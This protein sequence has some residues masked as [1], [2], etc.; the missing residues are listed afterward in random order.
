M[1]WNTSGHVITHKHKELKLNALFHGQ[2][3]QLILEYFKA[4]KQAH[5]NKILQLPYSSS[6]STIQNKYMHNLHIP[7][8]KADILHRLS[9]TTLSDNAQGSSLCSLNTKQSTLHL[10]TMLLDCILQY[11]T[12]LNMN[13]LWQNKM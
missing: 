11:L 12:V 6:D 10:T 7:I 1:G 13:I 4:N 2:P 9:I 8:A 5:Y 3:M